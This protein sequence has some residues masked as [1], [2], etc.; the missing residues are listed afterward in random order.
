MFVER[1]EGRERYGVPILCVRHN[2]HG[3]PDLVPYPD[4]GDS[5]DKGK[6]DSGH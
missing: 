2:L 5:A 1:Q 4:A 6:N 3:L